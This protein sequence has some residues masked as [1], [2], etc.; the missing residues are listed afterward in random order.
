MKKLLLILLFV[1]A[2]VPL[3]AEELR[4]VSLAP[5]LTELI[6]RL[7]K[8]KALVG[9]SSACNYPLSIRNIP[10]AGEFGRPNPERVVA[11][12]PT[13]V[14]ANALANP[15]AAEMLRSAGIK[16]LLKQC[17]NPEEYREWV[18][19]AGKELKCETE[20]QKENDR[21]EQELAELRR[22]K[23]SAAGKTVLC[24]IW[25]NPPTAAG[26]GSL[27][28]TVIRLAGQR[29]I[30]GGI[31]QDYFNP[32]FEWLLKNQPD[33]L[34]L[35]GFSEK[36]VEN[37]KKSLPWT[38]LKAVRENQIISD[39]DPDLLLRPGPRLTQGIRLLAERCRNQKGKQ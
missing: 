4:V 32:S 31:R 39:I 22:E 9:R 29:N 35:P 24:L 18:T 26:Q 34:L 1:T 15:A 3:S 27:P 33:I 37:L 11:L 30:A 36:Q 12:K 20:A 2:L 17:R 16:V 23:H 28:D 19:I 7:G 8:E 14:F 5:A 13:H 21:I 10:V 38:K 25:D 6:C